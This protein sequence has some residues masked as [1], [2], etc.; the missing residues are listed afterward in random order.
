MAKESKAD[1]IKRFVTG[2]QPFQIE[3]IQ[4]LIGRT[5]TYKTL[6]TLFTKCF[7]KTLAISSRKGKG[8]N[9]QK[10]IAQM[11][12]DLTEI[13]WGKD[14]EI[15]SREMGQ[16]GADVRMSERVQKLF[17][18]GIECK[19]DA[20][21]N[22]KK[23][24]QQAIANTKPGVNWL[25]FHKQTGQNKEDQVDMVAIIDAIHFFE[26]LQEIK[27]LKNPPKL[28]RRTKSD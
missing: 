26:L 18:Y 5:T 28:L 14:T 9:C 10:E 6:T 11:I 2:L 12:S 21:W 27:R 13:P 1:K 4:E 23:A 19:D 17:P 20:S 15:V 25:V 7:K 8:R 24:I 22:I 3:E 16:S